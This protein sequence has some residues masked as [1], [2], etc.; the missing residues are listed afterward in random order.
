MTGFI[1]FLLLAAGILMLLGLTPDIIT[2]DLMKMM[3]PRH[4]LRD[5]VKI[6]QGKKKSRK[7]A[8]ALHCQL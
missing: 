2:R 3:A 7:I 5:K 4:S 1:C 8:A 6:A